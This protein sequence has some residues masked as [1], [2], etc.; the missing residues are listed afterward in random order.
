MASIQQRKRLRVGVVGLGRLWE[1]RHK[2]ALARMKDRFQVVA[3]YDQVA[4]EGR[5]SRPR[6]SA[7]GPWKAWR[8]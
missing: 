3:V 6:S 1:V 2:P 8:R 7:A 4:P 5:E